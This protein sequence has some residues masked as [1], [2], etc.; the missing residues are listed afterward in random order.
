MPCGIFIVTDIPADKV[1]E[2]QQNF[3]FDAP[4]T[5]TVSAPDANGKVSITATFPPCDDGSSPINTTAHA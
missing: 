3:Q 5:V 4:L 2:V 1:G